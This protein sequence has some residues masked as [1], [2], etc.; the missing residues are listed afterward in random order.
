[1]G[2]VYDK[3][4]EENGLKTSDQVH[5]EVDAQVAKR[6]AQAAAD[7]AAPDAQAAT[8]KSKKGN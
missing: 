8:V 3:I 1:M 7:N 2:N 4:R 5:A 6:D